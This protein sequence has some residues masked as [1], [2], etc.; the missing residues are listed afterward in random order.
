LSWRGRDTAKREA[1][2]ACLV[3]MLLFAN[4]CL[5]IIYNCSRQI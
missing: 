1:M 2:A 4:F 3:I 5:H